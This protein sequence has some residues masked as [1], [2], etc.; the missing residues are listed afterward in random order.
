MKLHQAVKKETLHMIIGIAVLTVLE[1]IVFVL[2]AKWTV[3]VLAGSVWSASLMAGNF[4]ALALT[5]QAA[6]D[7]ED[8]KRAR[9]KMQF[10]YSMRML[11]LLAGLVLAFASPVF[12]G[13][14]ALPPL[15]FP[16][17]TIFVMQLMGL[18]QPKKENKEE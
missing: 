5:V 3:Q 15:L 7:A 2:L 17:L 6:T 9:L 18:Y 4:F 12:D 8:E 11:V 13:I 14:A 1:N 10:S 16:R